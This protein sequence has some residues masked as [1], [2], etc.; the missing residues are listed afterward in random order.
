MTS[1]LPKEKYFNAQLY[2]GDCCYHGI[3]TPQDY[4]QAV[5]WY[6]EAAQQGDTDA[7][8][9][10]GICYLQG[11]GTLQ[12]Y[13]QAVYWIGKASRGGGLHEAQCL[14]DSCYQ[15]ELADKKQ[16]LS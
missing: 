13:K 11:R 12:D 10:L 5:F 9:N 14:Y 1:E 4:K 16:K 7:Q 15:Y 3:T 8:F 6:K 2:L